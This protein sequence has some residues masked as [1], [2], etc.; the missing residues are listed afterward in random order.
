IAAMLPHLVLLELELL[1]L[2]TLV[3]GQKEEEEAIPV[4]PGLKTLKLP[5][6]YNY[7]DTGIEKFMGLFPSL[8]YVQISARYVATSLIYALSTLPHLWSLEIANGTLLIETIEYLLEK[9]PSLECLSVG[10]NEMG[11]KL[12]LVL[13]KCTAMHTLILRGNYTPGFL[14]SL[15]QPSPLMN[16]LKVL[17]VWRYTN[18]GKIKFSPKDKHSKDTAME[19]FECAVE[20]KY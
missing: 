6:I 5:N 19:K 10:V 16:T 3:L 9:L 20:I 7:S 14:A 12:A 13:S 17:S 4:L 8:E 1:S 15:L 18:K 11:N 2:G